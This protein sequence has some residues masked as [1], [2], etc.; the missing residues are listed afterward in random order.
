[1]GKSYAAVAVLVLLALAVSAAANE[2]QVV[3]AYKNCIAIRTLNA[4]HATLTPGA[5][6]TVT[7]D[8][9]AKAS[10]YDDSD[11]DGVF[12][13][14][15]DGTAPAHPKMAVVNKGEMYTFT[16]SATDFYAFIVDKSMKDTADNS[17]TMYVTLTG[18]GGS[19]VV[20]EIQA[21]FNCIGLEEFGSAKK[22]LVGEQ[23]YATSVTGD[24]ATNGDPTGFFEG[25]CLFHRHASRPYHPIF[26]V[27]EIGE[28][29]AIT[30]HSTGW[31][32]C[33]LLDE[34]VDSMGNNTGAML[35][36]FQE[37]TPVEA[38]TWGAVKA[39]YR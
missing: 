12:I 19:R 5:K 22:I 3:D 11:Y 15:Y 32:Y 26:K 25:V 14:Y 16:A 9:D 6:Y 38:T 27:L 36:E 4:P 1:M 39:N 24:A 10:F 35:I 21:M 34:T 30:P 7:V 18:P 31:V 13:Y 2:Y 33:F 28:D 8:G 37:Q 20:L 29:Y 17:G 23:T